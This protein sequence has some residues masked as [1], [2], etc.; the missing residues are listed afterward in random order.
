MATLINQSP[1][2]FTTKEL[3]HRW[4]IS[5]RTLE[6]WRDQGVGPRYV[7]IGSRVRY[8]IQAIERA[9]RDWSRTQTENTE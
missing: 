1:T 9:E 7:K 2:F 5:P 6:G 8:P 4:R 3:A